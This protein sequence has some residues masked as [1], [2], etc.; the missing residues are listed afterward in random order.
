MRGGS[1]GGT[2]AARDGVVI[3]PWSRGSIWVIWEDHR[4]YK[5]EGS[6]EP[7]RLAGFLST[8]KHSRISQIFSILSLAAYF[9]LLSALRIGWSDLNFG[10]MYFGTSLEY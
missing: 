4:I 2:R 10:A 5:T 8:R 3:H 6:D 7:Q 1:G 9:S